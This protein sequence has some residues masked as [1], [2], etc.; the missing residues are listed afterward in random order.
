MADITTLL[1]SAIAGGAP[2]NELFELLYGELKSLARQ[3]S[4][5]HGSHDVHTTTLVHEAYLK[6]QGVGALRLE[7]R[8]HFLAYAS[9]VMRSIIVDHARQRLAIKR[10]EGGV[11]VT[12]DTN[13]SDS[14]TA[15]DAEVI[16][17]DEALA[18]LADLDER[19]AQIVEL[20]YFGD[21]SNEEIADVLEVSLR[22]VQRG[23]EKARLFLSAS[24]RSHGA[25]S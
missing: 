8:R 19:L 23:W 10:G 14:T 20:K 6:F 13:V 16:E 7:D 4:R 15:N 24:L 17:V 9:R 21:M 12:L 1:N 2:A 5:R 3:Q 25:L 22:T 11:P 18:K